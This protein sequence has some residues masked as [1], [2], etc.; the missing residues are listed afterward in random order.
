MAR[1]SR[2]QSKALTSK[3]LVISV[4]VPSFNHERF[5]GDTISSVIEQS[6]SEIEVIIVDD[7]SSDRSV[8]IIGEWSTRD[9]RIRRILHHSNMGIAKTVNDGIDA[10]NGKYLAFIAS[11]DIYETNALKRALGEL[12][13]NAELGGVLF[14]SR[15]VDD[16]GRWM[17]RS[18]Q[19]ILEGA[20]LAREGLA[21]TGQMALFN[22]VVRNE[23]AF[24]A[25]VVRRS[26]VDTHRIR[27]DTRL[28]Y[29]NDNLFWLDLSRIRKLLY[30]DECLYLH[31]IHKSAT[32]NMLSSPKAF[33]TDHIL[34]LQIILA[35]YWDALDVQS[36][37]FLRYNLA[38]SYL[39]ISDFHNAK[40]YCEELATHASRRTNRIKG[41]I[42][43]ILLAIAL[44][45]TRVARILIVMFKEKVK[46]LLPALRRRKYYA[47]TFRRILSG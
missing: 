31:R 47:R 25:G 1:S 15:W 43:V 21:V 7:C 33:H 46:V 14:G 8:E 3:K 37:R 28:R 20:S 23:G 22:S 2:R 34:E 30:I 26:V 38:I 10:A 4:I 9:S 32:S 11:D 17:S 40:K 45:N 12:E 27:F 44:R 19:T 24:Y 41:I 13:D 29:F 5:I 18:L 42:V 16:K 6:I 36:R 39:A 35:K